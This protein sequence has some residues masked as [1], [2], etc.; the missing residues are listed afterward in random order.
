MSEI[1]NCWEFK[2]CG[3]E[4]G[5]E[6]AEE[7]GVCPASM[8]NEADGLNSGSNGGRICWTIAGT[9]CGEE[10]KEGTFA[11]KTFSCTVCDFFEKVKDEEERFRF[12]QPRVKT[13]VAE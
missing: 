4:E 2:N 5:G 11:K 12:K 1:Q 10:T 9:C 3:R 8:A 6:K 13:T 7:L